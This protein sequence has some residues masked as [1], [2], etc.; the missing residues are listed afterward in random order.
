MEYHYIAYIDESGDDGLRVVK[1]IDQNG[2]SEWLVISAVVIAAH[3]EVESGA[4]MQKIASQCYRMQRK[5]VHFKD[6]NAATK[7]MACREVA[8]FP[9]R[10]FVVASNK[11]NMRGYQNPFAAEIPSKNWFYCWLTRIL[12]ERVTHW[13]KMRSL[14][15][16]GEVKKLRIEYSERGGLSYSQMTAYYE[17]LRMKSDA[18]NLYLPLG[19]LSW[20]VMHRDLLKVYHHA[21]RPGLQLADIVASSFFKAC[22]VYDT[23]GCDHQFAM[24][25]RDRMAR[26]LKLGFN[27]ISGYGVKLLPSL[28]EAKLLP[29]QREIF[30]WYGYPRQWWDPDPT[31]PKAYRPATWL[32]NAN[33]PLGR[34][35]A[36]LPATRAPRRPTDNEDMSY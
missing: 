3:R 26:D 19:D 21:A 7:A 33:R 5:T 10:C 1:P 28:P 14:L 25:L 30:Q 29:E 17:W 18:A 36:R 9:I 23:G 8:G 6:L 24:I 15:D 11:K 35:G 34:R 22:D 2:S 20:E 31:N 4:W 16:H 12:L 32:D 13:V 27:Y